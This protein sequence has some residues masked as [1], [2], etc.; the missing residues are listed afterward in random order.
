M[1]GKKKKLDHTIAICFLFI[2]LF[3]LLSLQVLIVVG[4]LRIKSLFIYLFMKTC[5]C[6]LERSWTHKVEL[7]YYYYELLSFGCTGIFCQ[8]EMV[9]LCNVLCLLYYNILQYICIW[10]WHMEAGWRGSVANES[11]HCIIG[12]QIK[13]CELLLLNIKLS[14]LN[15]RQPSV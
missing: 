13:S 4:S 8:F 1:W 14:G 2:S 6:F 10:L 11:N 3:L 15:S 9:M 7:Y 5:S 12:K